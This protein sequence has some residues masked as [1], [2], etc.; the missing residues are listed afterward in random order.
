MVVVCR[1]ATHLQ[2]RAHT[3][4][5]ADAAASRATDGDAATAG[6]ADAPAEYVESAETDNSCLICMDKPKNTLLF[7][8][9]H[10]CACDGCA[11][12]LSTQGT[13]PVCRAKIEKVIKAFIT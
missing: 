8:C 5:A 6:A 4:Q 3:Q 10:V 1:Y 9:G 7:P 12:I 11:A 2:K 13:C